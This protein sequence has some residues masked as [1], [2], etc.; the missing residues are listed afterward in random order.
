MAK[1]EIQKALTIPLRFTTVDGQEL[2][3]TGYTAVPSERLRKLE[4]LALVAKGVVEA[5]EEA[6][7]TGSTLRL[8]NAQDELIK[9]VSGLQEVW[10]FR[11][12]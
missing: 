6:K 3:I 7:A 5:I 2:P 1:A 8:G 9:E 4:Q 12:S 10:D 11:V